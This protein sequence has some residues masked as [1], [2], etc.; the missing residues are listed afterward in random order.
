MAVNSAI[1]TSRFV[2]ADEELFTIFNYLLLLLTKD[3]AQILC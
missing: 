2:L 3:A 1:P